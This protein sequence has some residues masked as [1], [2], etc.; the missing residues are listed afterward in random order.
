MLLQERRDQRPQTCHVHGIALTRNWYS[1]PAVVEG[2]LVLYIRTFVRMSV[3]SLDSSRFHVP[4]SH[5]SMHAFIHL[6]FR[7]IMLSFLPSSFH[8]P[9][10]YSRKWVQYV[11]IYIPFLHQSVILRYPKAESITFDCYLNSF[12]ITS[13]L[14][15]HFRYGNFPFANSLSYLY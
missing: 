10:P 7:S 3:R 1:T 9:T 13:I 15:N 6:V 5:L 12:P 4:L 11:I 14:S 2:T 8:S